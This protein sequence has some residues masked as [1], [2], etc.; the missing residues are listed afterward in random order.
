MGFAAASCLLIFGFALLKGNRQFSHLDW[1]CLSL[2]ILAIALWVVTDQPLIAA[3]LVTAGDALGYI[4]TY[5]KG[6]KKPREENIAPMLVGAI[7]PILSIPA[8]E[9]FT[10]S[11]W[12]YPA[13]LIL[14]NGGFVIMIWLRR[15]ATAT[16]TTR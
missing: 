9:N 11:N 3:V 10:L 14:S 8:L 15:R 4:P 16:Q 12:L 2:A 6:Y 1:I 7:I 13:S 5:V